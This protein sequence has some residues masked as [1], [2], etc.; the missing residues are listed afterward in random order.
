LFFQDSLVLIK[1][2]YINGNLQMEGWTK[3]DD[4][5]KYVGEIKWYY[6][7]GE[8]SIIKNYLD[9]K[10]NGKQI[11]FY[12]NGNKESETNYI[13]GTKEGENIEYNKNGEISIKGIYKKGRPYSGKFRFK[14]RNVYVISNYVEGEKQ[15]KETGFNNANQIITE[16]IY[17]DGKKTEGTFIWLEMFRNNRCIKL[18]NFKQGEEEGKQMYYN[19]DFSKIIGYYTIENGKKEG[20]SLAYNEEGA[21]AY[22][23]LYKAGEPYD[24]T[25]IDENKNIQSYKEGKLHGK[26]VV[27]KKYSQEKGTLYYDNGL[28][29]EQEY[30]SFAIEGEEELRGVYKNGMPYNG[31]FVRNENEIFLVDYYKKG[32]KKYQY[33]KGELFDDNYE[34]PFL[35]VKSTYKNGEIYDG[36]SYS[37]E[38]KQT[39]K[40]RTLK[41]GKQQSLTIWVFAMHYANSI[42]I[43][44]TD[45]GFVMTEGRAPD[46]KLIYDKKS[47]SIK[48]KEEVIVNRALLDNSFSNETVVY[49]LD[50]DVLKTHA[51][52]E[53]NTILELK[54]SNNTY[55]GSLLFNLFTPLFR[56]KND[57]EKYLENIEA[58]FK[59]FEDVSFN[60]D[61]AIS[62]LRYNE[63]GQPVEGMLVEKTAENY[64]GKLYK[65]EKL[66]D[67]LQAV[68]IEKLRARFKTEFE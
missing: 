15:G 28:L 39:L 34:N 68:T 52:G 36:V 67:T 23:M 18:T 21:L 31:Y 50:G 22:K 25:F 1:D 14:R 19:D 38:E 56:K 42:T 5:R 51:F 17:V 4:E 16:G 3:K 29:I 54:A 20:E 33:S 26:Q 61:Q 46:L 40:I 62:F 12:N 53:H 11:Y 59:G 44:N 32:K 37:M 10:L 27:N 64:M 43:E 49:Y 8:L 57:I 58:L 24:G 9:E 7:N 35:S 41:K 47:L 60:E 55:R 63:E 2:Y 30:N 48:D 13:K 45:F 65:E 6:S 66:I